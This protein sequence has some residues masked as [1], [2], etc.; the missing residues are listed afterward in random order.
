MK[1]AHANP[2][3][4][5]QRFTLYE[6]II[7]WAVAFSFIYLALTGL[8]LWD[9]RLYWLA[10][11]FGGGDSIRA[12]HPWVGLVFTGAFVLMILMWWREMLLDRDDWRWLRLV[13][14][15]AQ[16]DEESM[17]EPG[18]YNAGQKML[19]W[20]QIVL[21]VLLLISGIVI[22]YPEVTSRNWRLAAIVIHSLTAVLSM[23]VIIVHIYMA[24]AA[25][26][27]SFRAMIEGW[28]ERGWAAKHH[29][30]WYRK[31]TGD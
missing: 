9:T 27:G 5:I 10:A 8:A 14:R 30:K 17:P 24:T 16:N 6:R 28:V 4:G 11:I 21:T 31:V 12:W 19:F 22:W 20:S 13:H 3:K 23:A 7:H 18:K 2:S 26:P 15:Y 1:N 25:T 29:P